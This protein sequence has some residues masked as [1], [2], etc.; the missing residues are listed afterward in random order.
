MPTRAGTSIQ[1]NR[2]FVKIVLNYSANIFGN[3]KLQ[4]LS[5]ILFQLVYREIAINLIVFSII[6]LDIDIA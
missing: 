3:T 6:L 1:F 2:V 4:Y 5:L